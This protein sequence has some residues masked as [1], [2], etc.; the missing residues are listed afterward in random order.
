MIPIFSFSILVNRPLMLNRYILHGLAQ[1]A[2][3]LGPHIFKNAMQIKVAPAFFTAKRSQ[4]LWIFV[5]FWRRQIYD[6]DLAVI[7]FFGII[8]SLGEFSQGLDQKSKWNLTIFLYLLA[9]RRLSG[10]RSHKSRA[11]LTL[12]YLQERQRRAWWLVK[13]GRD[14][15]EGLRYA[16]SHV[17]LIQHIHWPRNGSMIHSFLLSWL[18]LGHNLVILWICSRL[19]LRYWLSL[20]WSLCSDHAKWILVALRA[21]RLLLHDHFV[22]VHLCR[23]EGLVGLP[24]IKSPLQMR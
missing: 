5:A 9:G 12:I 4:P 6:W 20:D 14:G 8:F 17:G 1:I 10:A 3:D 11:R 2:F 23:L 16:K 7:A 15:F 13:W 21:S 19:G 24:W 22:L 18:L